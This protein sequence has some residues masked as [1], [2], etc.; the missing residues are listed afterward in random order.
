MDKG[1]F[2]CENGSQVCRTEKLPNINDNIATVTPALAKL[3]LITIISVLVSCSGRQAVVNAPLDPLL[4]STPAPTP[5]AFD[6]IDFAIELGPEWK[7]EREGNSYIFNDERT[8]RQITIAVLRPKKTLTK[9][10][11]EQVGRE[12]IKVRQGVIKELS[13]GNA[14][15]G[16][17]KLVEV[18]E[19]FDFT[20]SATDPVNG[21]KIRSTTFARSQRIVT[22]SFNKYRPSPTDEELD[23]QFASILV[24]VKLKD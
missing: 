22:V 3:L 21:V 7:M 16:E 20:F 8:L 5:L 2:D 1:N 13:N 17:T 11:I 24:E 18:P 19:G 6:S 23:R 14:T 12:T 4:T 9:T 10:E 15:L